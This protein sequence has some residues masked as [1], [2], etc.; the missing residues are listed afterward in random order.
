[1]AGRESLATLGAKR[2]RLLRQRIGDELANARIVGGLSVREV[3]RKVGVSADR[4]ARAERGDPS[5]LTLDLAARLAPIV[6]LQL[7]TTLHLNG[8]PVRD[9]AHLALLDRFRRRLHPSLKWRTEVPMPI[10]GDLRSADGLIEG[11]FGTALVEAETR[12]TDVQSV[13]RKS[14][15]K[16][17][18]LG[19][20]GASCWS[21][22]PPRTEGRS[23]SILSFGIATQ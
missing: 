13:E 4:V 16:A 6:G 8:D 20:E 19:A 17:R 15:L 11:G 18:D 2:S 22:T 9:R 3:S 21:L 14:A 1:M 7:A 12:I 10:P 23:S 5:A